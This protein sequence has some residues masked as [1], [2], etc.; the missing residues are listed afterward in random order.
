MMNTSKTKEHDMT[1]GGVDVEKPNIDTERFLMT[2]KAFNVVRRTLVYSSGNT[3]TRDVVM[4][5]PVV[6]V[7]VHNTTEDTYLLEREYRSGIDSI[8][9]GVPAGFM[10]SGEQP[11]QSMLRE[12]HEETGIKLHQHTL[13]HHEQHIHN[14][15]YMNSSEGF[16]NE[17]SNLFILDIG[18]DDYSCTD[19]AL[20]D[21]E[22]IQYE[23]VSASQLA[24][25]VNDG[26][27]NGASSIILVQKE[28]L[29]RIA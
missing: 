16:T 13:D 23:W 8:A 15:G 6:A 18:N 22:Y 12:L 26:I 19:Q 3:I 21:D 14:V 1:W 11:E 27:I 10:E 28:I 5:A 29:R 4:H 2:G 7:L 17:K 25:M 9:Y 20:D 24:N